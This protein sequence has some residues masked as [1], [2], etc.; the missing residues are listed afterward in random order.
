M[1]FLSVKKSLGRSYGRGPELGFGGREWNKEVI[2]V[3]EE[4]TKGVA[5]LKGAEDVG[6]GRG[7][8]A[9]GLEAVGIVSPAIK[10]DM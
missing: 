5:A 2:G 10:E 7:E 6:K 3:P 8:S 1:P 4:L 9:E